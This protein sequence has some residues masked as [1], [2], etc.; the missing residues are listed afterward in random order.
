MSNYP[1]CPFCGDDKVEFLGNDTEKKIS[2]FKCPA[3]PPQGRV[4]S[5]RLA[6]LPRFGFEARE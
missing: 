4:F 1:P 5:L 3:H 2:W 6:V